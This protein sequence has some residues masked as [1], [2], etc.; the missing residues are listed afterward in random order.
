MLFKCQFLSGSLCSMG[1]I[2]KQFGGSGLAGS[3]LSLDGIDCNIAYATG[4]ENEDLVRDSNN[5]LGNHISDSDNS[6]REGFRKSGLGNAYIRNDNDRERDKMDVDHD[7]RLR[8]RDGERDEGQGQGQG[9]GRIE[10]NTNSGNHHNIN[11][12]KSH[13]IGFSL[14]G[15]LSGVTTAVALRVSEIER[16]SERSSERASVLPVADDVRIKSENPHDLAPNQSQN[17]F[18]NTMNQNINLNQN[19]NS[20]RGLYNNNDSDNRIVKTISTASKV[21]PTESQNLHSYSQNDNIPLGPSPRGQ[22]PGVSG[23]LHSNI[24]SPILNVKSEKFSDLSTS[25]VS[26]SGHVSSQSDYNNNNNNNNNNSAKQIVVSHTTS[27]APG[28]AYSNNISVVESSQYQ[29]HVP[30]QQLSQVP[31]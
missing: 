6:R 13:S 21:I 11:S 2:H 14:D 4:M 5:N 26:G 16:S 9:Q 24:E 8:E 22:I 19:Q 3:M 30:P 20:D 27:G 29:S 31:I 15:R 28:I 7:D 18:F 1:N 12:H 17:Q 10:D 23:N 25:G